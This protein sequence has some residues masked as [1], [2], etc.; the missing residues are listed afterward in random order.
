MKLMNGFRNLKVRTKIIIMAVFMLLVMIFLAG[1]AMF[2]QANYSKT[3][4]KNLEEEI[5]SGYDQN[6]KKSGGKCS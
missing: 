1:L 3:N 5:R 6:I 2:N 4:L